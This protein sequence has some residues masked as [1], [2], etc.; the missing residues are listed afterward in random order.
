MLIYK[1][2][3]SKADKGKIGFEDIKKIIR[4]WNEDSKG[5]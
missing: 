2:G 1:Y 4:R 5:R 3:L